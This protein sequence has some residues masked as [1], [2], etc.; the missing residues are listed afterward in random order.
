[1]YGVRSDSMDE[2]DVVT[3]L[4]GA[5]A[6]MADDSSN[7]VLCGI[8]DE[9]KCDVVLFSMEFEVLHKEKADD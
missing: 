9:L 4:R 2:C 1:M 8:I 5:L 7:G 3:G 6:D